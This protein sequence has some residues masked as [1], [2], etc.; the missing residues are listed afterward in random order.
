[1]RFWILALVGSWILDL[2]AVARLS[3]HERDLE[4]LILRHQIGV[5]GRNVKRPSVSRLE[6][7]TL[8]LLANRLKARA[9]LSR[10]QLRQSVLIFTPEIVLGW[11]RTLV[12]R[13]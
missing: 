7:L 10:R 13:R 1:M 3:D 6:K 5:L 9:N 11:H 4:I 12:R 2:L 8:A